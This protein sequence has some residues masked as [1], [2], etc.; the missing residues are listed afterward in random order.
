MKTTHHFQN[1][2]ILNLSQSH[3]NVR[4][5]KNRKT[6]LQQQ[7]TGLARLHHWSTRNRRSDELLRPSPQSIPTCRPKLLLFTAIRR[8]R[9]Y[10]TLCVSNASRS[11]DLWQRRFLR[12]QIVTVETRTLFLRQRLGFSDSC[13]RKTIALQKVT[14]RPTSIPRFPSINLIL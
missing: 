1:T 12:R 5:K 4:G 7:S 14:Q 13:N 6:K 8:S 11:K 3:Q 10:P 2:E 9:R